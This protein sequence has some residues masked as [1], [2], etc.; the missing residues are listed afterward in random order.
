MV[1]VEQ[2]LIIVV[3]SLD[4]C[5]LCMHMTL[6][7]YEEQFQ[8]PSVNVIFCITNSMTHFHQPS[9]E[10]SWNCA[11]GDD[12]VLKFMIPLLSLTAVLNNAKCM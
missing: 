8:L 2:D 5:I 9:H 3:I 4:V 10:L 11:G 6:Y 12:S 7:Y 1:V